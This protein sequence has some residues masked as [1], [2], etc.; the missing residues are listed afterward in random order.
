MHLTRQKAIERNN[1][2]YKIKELFKQYQ[3]ELKK[4]EDLK[5][6][7]KRYIKKRI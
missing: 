1:L 5:N 3:T 2:E 4:L 6:K 7:K